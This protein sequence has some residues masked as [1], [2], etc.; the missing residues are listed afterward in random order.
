MIDI[1]NNLAT[2]NHSISAAA[3]KS[4]RS[5]GDI[6]LIG[7]TKTVGPERIGQL[8]SAGVNNLGE[9]R[10]QEFLPK[11]ESLQQSLMPN[12]HFIGHLQRNKVKFIIDKVVMIHSVDSISLAR[13]IDS[14][15]G[16]ADLIMDILVEV[17]IAGEDSKHGIAPH[18]AVPFMVEL[19]KLS[20]IRVKGLMCIAPFVEKSEENR[21]N[22]EKMRNLLIDI[23]AHSLHN[24][25]LTELSMGMSGDYEVAIEEGATMVRIGTALVG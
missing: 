7:V 2:I 15:A 18:Q 23:N 20:H 16:K 25:S 8:L 22:F 9:N 12:W 5:P 11:Y 14:R 19:A 17:N 3:K 6:Q 24:H 13:E 1:V 21:S 4:G 10:V